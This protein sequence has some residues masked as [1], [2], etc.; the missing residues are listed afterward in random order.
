MLKNKTRIYAISAD[1]YEQSR[2]VAREMALPFDLLCDPERE[3]VNLYGLLNPYEHGGIARPAIFVILPSGVIGYRSIDGTARRVDITHLLGY[4][5][6]LN[7][8]PDL[9]NNELPPKKWVFPSWETVRQIFKNMVHRGNAA[10]WI[11]YAVFP[12]YPVII[13]VRKMGKLFRTKEKHD[14]GNKTD[15]NAK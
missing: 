11:H 15:D 5:S 12:L 3:V 9:K 6:G 7:K 8:N 14:G 4:L 10:D 1:N 13:P 2:A